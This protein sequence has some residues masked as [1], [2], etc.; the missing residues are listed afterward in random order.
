MVGVQRQER[1]SDARN[2]LVG[3][4]VPRQ[5]EHQEERA[6]AEHDVGDLSGQRMIAEDEEQRCQETR[7]AHRPVSRRIV[8]FRI[9]VSGRNGERAVHVPARVGDV[10]RDGKQQDQSEPRRH[11]HGKTTGHKISMSDKPRESTFHL[12]SSRRRFLAFAPVERPGVAASLT[13]S[14]LNVQ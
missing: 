3:K 7:I 13:G 10:G 1:D 9:A 11:E 6:R 2:P 4:H 5:S 14:C 12:S 8:A